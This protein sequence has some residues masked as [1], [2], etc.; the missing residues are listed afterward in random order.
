MA[1]MEPRK[2]EK[3]LAKV[4]VVL[5][6]GHLLDQIVAHITACQVKANTTRK[7]PCFAALGGLLSCRYDRIGALKFLERWHNRQIIDRDIEDRARGRAAEAEGANAAA[8]D[9]SKDADADN[10]ADGTLQAEEADDTLQV[11]V[12]EVTAPEKLQK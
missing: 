10:D 4:I 3:G 11:T 7:I 12:I 1:Y 6:D 9:N 5:V 2:G 8:A